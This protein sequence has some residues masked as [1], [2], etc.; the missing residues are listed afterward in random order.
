M[1]IISSFSEVFIEN[2]QSVQQWRLVTAITAHRYAQPMAVRRRSRPRAKTTT[3]QFSKRPHRTHPQIKNKQKQITQHHRHS[4]RLFSFITKHNRHLI[5][6]TKSTR[7]K[8]IYLT[9]NNN[10]TIFTSR[11]KNSDFEL[12]TNMYFSA[13]S[14]QS[15][16]D[17]SRNCIGGC[18]RGH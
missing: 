17:L 16:S 6:S 2:S 4:P 7:F 1:F 18:L 10:Q 8:T 11:K 12:T 9:N 13:S 5:N 15:T 14:V 3:R